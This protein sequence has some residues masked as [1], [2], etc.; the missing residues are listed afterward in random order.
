[1]SCERIIN[2][3][4]PSTSHNNKRSK[5]QKQQKL[6]TLVQSLAFFRFRFRRFFLNSFRHQKPRLTHSLTAAATTL[7]LRSPTLIGVQ[8][9][10][11]EVER[12]RV[13]KSATAT[14]WPYF[15]V[16]VVVWLCWCCCCCFEWRLLLTCARRSTKTV[17][18]SWPVSQYYAWEYM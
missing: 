11:V 12:E 10:R 6:S 15:I 14:P 4:I 17:Q 18:L 9:G 2:T 1:M 7:R 8:C 16:F 5:K 3:Y 13:S